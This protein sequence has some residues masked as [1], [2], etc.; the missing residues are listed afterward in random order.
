[1]N[2]VKI[3]DFILE[4]IDSHKEGEWW[5]FKECF[6]KS[7]TDLI[8]DI[9]C[10]ANQSSKNNGYLIFGV[11]DKTFEIVGVECDEHRKNQQQIIDVLRN[12]PFAGDYRPDIS[13]ETIIIANHEIDVL[14]VNNTSNVPYF[15]SK[16]YGEQT[17]G[18]SL[19][20]GYIYTRVGDTNTPKN[21]TADFYKT[22]LLWRKRFGLND[23]VMDRLHIA[24]DDYNN[25]VFDW[26]NKRYSYN[27]F[28]PEFQMV[29]SGDFA[30]S[31]WPLA[32]FY[33]A[34]IM[35]TVKLN[36][37][38]YNTVIYETELWALD[39]FKKFVP[40]ADNKSIIDD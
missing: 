15:L 18:P 7:K 22:E 34:P 10:L 8:H 23:G 24:L 17:G 19:H 35:H 29:I 25:W 33:T 28:L 39:E 16:D 31:W 37:M 3:I 26:G 12:V 30:K 36:V 5:D 13:L 27:K 40:K 38:I 2:E 14:I 6:A 21:A 32:A 4:L 1:M 9:I 20:K 11:R